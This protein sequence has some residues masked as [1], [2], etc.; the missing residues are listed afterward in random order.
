MAEYKNI[1]IEIKGPAC[2]ITINR[3]EKRNALDPETW[4]EIRDSFKFA[5]QEKDARVVILTGAG[6]KAFASGADIKALNERKALETLAS[7]VQDILCR[8]EDSPLPVIAAIDGFCLGGGCELA[9]ACDIRFATKRS[10]L[11]QPEVG[12]GIL[13]GAGG[14]Q[15]LSRLVGLGKA[16]ELILTGDILSADQAREI[17]LVNQVADSPEELM[18]LALETAEKIASKGPL[19]VALAK[20]AANAGPDVDMKHGLLLEKLAQAVLFSTND[21]L[22]GTLAF[23][24]K[25]KPEFTGT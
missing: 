8:I 23:L 18:A 11:G 3:P 12:L 10:R 16:K 19:A 7:P 15:R 2:I 9:M 1:L 22:E 24:E 4:L 5:E 20:M 21:R 13:P 25:R 14:T 6:G 17:G